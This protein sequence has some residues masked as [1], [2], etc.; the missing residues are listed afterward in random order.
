[1]IEEVICIMC[2]LGCRMKVQHGKKEISQVN[3]NKCKEGTTYAKK[4]ISFPGRVLT[5]TVK[6]ESLAVP[7][8]PVRSD[9]EIPKERLM[10]CM[11]EIARHRVSGSVESGQTIIKNTLGLGINIVACCTLS[12]R[13]GTS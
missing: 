7:L 1:M 2:P 10:D 11:R 4:E 5:T 8:L 9:K 12:Q 3:G 13:K 6:T